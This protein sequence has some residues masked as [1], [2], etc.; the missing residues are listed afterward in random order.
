MLCV[1]YL[2]GGGGGVLLLHGGGEVA[3]EELRELPVGAQI[4]EVGVVS[5]AVTRWWGT[6]WIGSCDSVM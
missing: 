3:A 6:L 5:D 1:Y 4:P 2:R